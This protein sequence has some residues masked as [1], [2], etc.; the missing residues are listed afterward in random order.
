MGYWYNMYE[1]QRKK[2][3]KD[4]IWYQFLDGQLSKENLGKI[5]DEELGHI[6]RKHQD[7]FRASIAKQI[8]TKVITKECSE[9]VACPYCGYTN[10][11]H[12]M[13]DFP[14]CCYCGQAFNWI[15]YGETWGDVE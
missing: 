13:H 3:V 4:L 5:S 14:Y 7:L 12:L 8:P 9:D 6:V 1:A 11:V 2:Q 10:S 15:G